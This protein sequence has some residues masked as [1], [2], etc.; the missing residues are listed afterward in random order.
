MNRTNVRDGG[1][2]ILE[3]LVAL[4][5]SSLVI[6]ALGGLLSLVIKARTGIDEGTR[7]ERALIDLQSILRLTGEAAGL[8]IADPDDA[9]FTLMVASAGPD[10]PAEVSSRVTLEVTPQTKV[11]ALQ[12]GNR[13]THA[14]ISVFDSV[15]LEYLHTGSEPVWGHA[16]SVVAGPI[17]AA[18]LRLAFRSRVWRPL[19][20]IV[21]PFEAYHSGATGT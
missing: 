7:I 10:H 2:S 11:L 4:A 5:L 21:S 15:A 20:W 19:L 17:I 1:F 9:A 18:R 3:I 13:N 14:D 12:R 16:D 8:T 6:M